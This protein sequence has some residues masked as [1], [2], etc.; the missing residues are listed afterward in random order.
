MWFEELN[1]K[2]R[3]D[4]MAKHKN[5]TIRSAGELHS[6]FEDYVLKL[7]GSLKDNGYDF[8]IDQDIPNIMIG[9]NGEIHKSNAGDHRFFIAKIVGV[10]L[11]PFTIKGVHQSFMTMHDIP[12]N[13]RGL[14]KLIQ[15]VNNLEDQ[16]S[17][18]D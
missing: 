9:R 3:T 14:E 12:N 18:S 13:K 5:I 7:V 6:F 2:L 17:S 15:V 10:P 1:N 4:G 11:M 16:Y 8:G